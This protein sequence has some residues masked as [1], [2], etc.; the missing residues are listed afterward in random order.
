MPERKIRVLLAKPG[1]DGHDRG[2]KVIARALHDATAIDIDKGEVE[3]R[4]IE[5]SRSYRLGFDQ[6]LIATGATPRRP[7]VPGFF[8]ERVHGVQTLDDGAH[9]LRHAKAS[10][11]DR[12]G[13]VSARPVVNANLALAC[14]VS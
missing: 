13:T 7:P 4:D 2:A 12:S 9:L 6:L 14:A 5:Q 3:V 1:L 8:D 11:A 10:G